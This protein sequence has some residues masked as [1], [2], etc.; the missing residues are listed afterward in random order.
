LAP[1]HFRHGGIGCAIRPTRY[2]APQ[3]MLALRKHLTK[4]LL[5]KR[6]TSARNMPG[7]VPAHPRFRE[8][9]WGTHIPAAGVPGSPPSRGRRTRDQA[10]SERSGRDDEREIGRR[11]RDRAMMESQSIVL[12]D[13]KAQPC[14]QFALLSL[15]N[16]NRPL[17]APRTTS[18]S[19][20]PH[21][22]V[23]SS[24][25]RMRAG[26]TAKVAALVG[27]L[28]PMTITN[29][30]ADLNCAVWRIAHER[31]PAKWG[32]SEPKCGW[33]VGGYTCSSLKRPDSGGA[34]RSPLYRTK[35]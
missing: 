10:T 17:R 18:R 24:E 2:Y 12:R 9:G 29:A 22:R 7:V 20:A 14:G 30:R 19:V 33:T 28:A 23:V 13:T 35:G 11:A 25:S 32:Y 5:P 31:M 16:K 8:D 3:L 4:Q 6:N 26:R 21:R 1:A 15:P 27:L 34:P